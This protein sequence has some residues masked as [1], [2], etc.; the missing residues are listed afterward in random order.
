MLE[1]LRG[2]SYNFADIVSAAKEKWEKAFI[3]G[4]KEALV[5]EADWSYEEE[6]GL[7]NTEMQSVAD[8]CR[9][10]ET[11]KMVNA[12]EVCG[13]VATIIVSTQTAD[14]YDSPSATSNGRL[15]NL[16]NF[17]SINRRLRCGII[18][19][20]ASA[21]SLTKPNL[22]TRQKHKVCL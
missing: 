13:V 14:A 22:R 16:W 20:R 12:I 7:L 8:Q 17:I 18:S 1:G 15:R 19:Y 9:K 4:A 6:F 10:D 3:E 21:N 5:E 11:K 2:E